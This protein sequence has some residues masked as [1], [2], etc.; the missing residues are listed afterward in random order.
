MTLNVN[1]LLSEF[2]GRETLVVDVLDEFARLT[3]RDWMGA[4]KRW[5]HGSLSLIHLH[6]LSVLGSGGPSTMSQLA[7]ALD[8]SLASATGIVD[9]MEKKGVIERQRSTEDRRVVEVHIT[10]RGRQTFT[11]LEVQRRAKLIELLA[12]VDDADLAAL[13]RGLRAFRAARERM[14]ADAPAPSRTVA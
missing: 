14:F 9:R 8:V 12:G 10:D 13:L 3:M 2:G 5:R 1:P 7:D 6:L 4:M 11:D